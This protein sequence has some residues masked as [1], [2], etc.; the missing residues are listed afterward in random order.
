MWFIRIPFPESRH[1]AAGKISHVFHSLRDR[2]K[3]G[4]AIQEPNPKSDTTMVSVV[5]LT[6]GTREPDV[7]TRYG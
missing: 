7:L 4:N 2:T 5:V 6:T 1:N 3:V